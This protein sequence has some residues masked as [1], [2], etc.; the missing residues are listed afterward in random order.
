[1]WGCTARRGCP[2]CPRTR[3]SRPRRGTAPGRADPGRWDPGE[4]P[5]PAPPP[6]PREP[7][8][9]RPAGRP[10]HE[11]FVAFRNDLRSVVGETP[12]TQARD[13]TGRRGAAVRSPTA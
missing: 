3:A 4:R 10:A 1:S 7:G 8:A 13:Y 5:A 2:R 6:V 11:L 12:A 9:V